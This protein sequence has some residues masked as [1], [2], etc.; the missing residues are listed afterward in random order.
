MWMKLVAKAAER[1]ARRNKVC[2]ILSISFRT[3]QRW[4]KQPDKV[5]KRAVPKSV[6]VNTLSEAEK[7]L[8]IALA[9]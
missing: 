8:V 6:P 3:P 9:R 5:D 7:M 4:E 2:E 1:G